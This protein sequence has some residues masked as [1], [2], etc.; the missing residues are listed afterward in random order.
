VGGGVS[1][2]RQYLNAGLVDEMH[3]AL[4]T[5][6]LGQGEALLAGIDLLALGFAC[7]RRVATEHATHVVLTKRPRP[8]A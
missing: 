3:L 7:T 5:V 2:I 8:P 6:L 1:T 4:T